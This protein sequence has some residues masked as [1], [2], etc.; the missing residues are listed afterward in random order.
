[1][2]LLAVDEAAAV[3]LVKVVEEIQDVL[4]RGRFFRGGGGGRGSGNGLRIH[5]AQNRYSLARMSSP[6]EYG[7]R[8]DLAP[9][10]ARVL[11]CWAM[12]DR[13]QVA[14]DVLRSCIKAPSLRE[15][16]RRL[17]RSPNYVARILRGELELTF[18]KVFEILQAA[19]VDASDFFE[20]LAGTLRQAGTDSA[21][22]EVIPPDER[23]SD[24]VRAL[25]AR[26][27]RAL[28]ERVAQQ[29][30]RLAGLEVEKGPAGRVR[31]EGSDADG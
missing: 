24:S 22:A 20:E 28:E 23:P 11:D 18:E 5:R 26:R 1:L 31:A 2:E 25:M 10:P 4:N 3:R 30:Q 16:D 19:R 7:F 12:A 14:R 15:L 17:G 8:R 6:F 13:L 9:G 29:E 27:L 21:M